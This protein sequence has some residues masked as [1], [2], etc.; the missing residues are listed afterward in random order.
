MNLFSIYI[1]EIYYKFII[2][3]IITINAIILIIN[4]S[5][6]IVLFILSPIKKIKLNNTKL[7]YNIHEDNLI[8]Y[9]NNKNNAYI[10]IIEINLPFLTTSYVYL[11]Y[12]ILI[13]F[14]ILIPIIIY[15][16]YISIAPILKKKEHFLVRWILLNITIFIIANIA[17]THNIIIPIFIQFLFTHYSEYQYYEFDVEFQL[18]RYLDT[19]FY[20][21]YGNFC[22]FIIYIIKKHLNINIH[23]ITIT[24]V[25]LLIIPL[26]IIIQLNLVTLLLLIKIYI[27]FHYNLLNQIKKYKHMEH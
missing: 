6:F 21:L 17:I 26:D 5:K 18:I 2:V 24:T 20:I 22:F 15:L 14:Y 7:N 1:K 13:T 11:K 12:I 3:L 19:Y 16:L 27:D 8:H 25:A 10:P 9:V 4:K 23:I